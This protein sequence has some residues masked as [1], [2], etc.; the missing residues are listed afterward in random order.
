MRSLADYHSPFAVGGRILTLLWQC[1]GKV[2]G[3]LGNFQLFKVA[4][5]VVRRD[6]IMME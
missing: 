3:E 6:A 1:Q 2:C 4:V 5:S